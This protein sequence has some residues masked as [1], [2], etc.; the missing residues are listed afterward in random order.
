M[1]KPFQLQLDLDRTEKTAQPSVAQVVELSQFRAR[2][3]EDKLPSVYES[4]TASVRHISL[5][6]RSTE[7]GDSAFG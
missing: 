7:A 2:K 1:E 6:P 5:R 4:I 3:A